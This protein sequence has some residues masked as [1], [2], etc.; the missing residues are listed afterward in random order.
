[1]EEISFWVNSFL[2]VIELICC[3]TFIAIV[4]T[5]LNDIS[6][7]YIKLIILFQ[8]YSFISTQLNGSKY[9]YVSLTIQLNI[10]FFY[11]E[12]N[13]Q[14]VLFKTIQL[15]VSHFIHTF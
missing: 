13:D 3:Q 2:N 8:Y 1:M 14:I 11:T 4:S 15:S 7:C 9:C 5:L 12:L 6:H 10:S